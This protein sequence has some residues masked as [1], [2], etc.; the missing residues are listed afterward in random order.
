M[1]QE[2]KQAIIDDLASKVK[3]KN[4]AELEGLKPKLDGL[5]VDALKTLASK[6]LAEKSSLDTVKNLLDE[7]KESVREIKD[8]LGDN[9]QG[10]KG[11]YVDFAE[12]NA[13]EFN[14]NDKNYNKSMTIKAPALMTTA[15]VT[16]NVAN[17]FNPLFGNYIDTNI[18]EVPKAEPVIMPLVNIVSAPGTE[19]IWWTER[20]NEEGDAQFIGEGDLKPLVDAE[21][22]A[23]SADIYEL[24]ERWKF[25]KRLMNHAPSVIDNFR[26]HANELIENKADDTVLAGDN[27]TNPLEFDGLDIVGSAFVVPP[28]LANYYTNANIFDAIN[29]LATTVRLSNFKGNLTCILNPVWKAVMQGIKNNDG[30]YIIPPFVT[31]DGLQVGETSVVFSNRYDATRI[32]VGELK[33]YN[34]VISENIEYD[35][36]YEN[37]DFSRNLV[38]RKLEMF[39]GSYIKGSDAGSII[40]DDIATVLTAIEVAP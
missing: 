14:A 39:A 3:T 10:K 22:S 18:G 29:A 24:A 4:D 7:V 25:S 13:K 9:G 21:W 38:S 16:P 5:D 11:I 1:T 19:K 12:K 8:N 31:R 15:N 37:D 26:T 33:K 2:E 20:V 35:E 17:G 30:D 36:G 34:L 28:Q 23:K 27:T 40:A 32:I 6:E